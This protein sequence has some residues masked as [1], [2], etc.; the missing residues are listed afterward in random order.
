MLHLSLAL[1]QHQVLLRHSLQ[2]RA[3]PLQ[4]LAFFLILPLNHL[5][6]L[7][8]HQPYTQGLLENQ[9]KEAKAARATKDQRRPKH[10]SMLANPERAPKAGI[11][12][13]TKGCLEITSVSPVHFRSKKEYLKSPTT[14]AQL[15]LAAPLA[16]LGLL[17][18][19]LAFLV[20]SL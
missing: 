2:F 1:H 12:M 17:W 7:L 13:T 18:C 5:S 3:V 15:S 10:S 16:H 4:C 20:H 9:A 19:Q 8:I 11:E 14:R 6:L